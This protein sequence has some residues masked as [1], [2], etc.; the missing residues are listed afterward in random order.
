MDSKRFPAYSML[1]GWSTVGRLACPCCMDKSDAFTLKF[2]G[3]QSWLI[4]TV[5]FYLQIIHS[6]G[7]ELHFQKIK[8]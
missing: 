3:K 1:S 7:I 2:S 4:T 6:V 8:Q 5:S